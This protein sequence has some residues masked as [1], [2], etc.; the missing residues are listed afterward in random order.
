MTYVVPWAYVI[1]EIGLWE[2]LGGVVFTSRCLIE[3][4][5]SLQIQVLYTMSAKAEYLI[6]SA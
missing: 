6:I 2:D 5:R 1:C 3:L 4:K